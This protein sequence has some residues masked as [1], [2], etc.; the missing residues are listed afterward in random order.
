[1][2]EKEKGKLF[3]TIRIGVGAPNDEQAEYAHRS[4]ERSSGLFGR[5]FLAAFR[6][7]QTGHSV[8]HCTIKM[9]WVTCAFNRRAGSLL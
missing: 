7:S 4:P 6:H 3:K 1:M 2:V 9:D 5:N 8:Q